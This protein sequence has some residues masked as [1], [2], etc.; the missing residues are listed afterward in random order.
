[1]TACRVTRNYDL[2][3]IYAQLLECL[4]DYPAVYLEAVAEWNRER[5]L[6]RKPIIHGED[7]HVL[8]LHLVGPLPCIVLV[9][10]AAHTH[11]S[12]AMEMKYDLLDSVLEVLLCCRLVYDLLFVWS[13]AAEEAAGIALL[14]LGID[15]HLLG[16]EGQLPGTE[17][18]YL[19]TV[20]FMMTPLIQEVVNILSLDSLSNNWHDIVF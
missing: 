6:R 15:G 17:N 12:T 4:S 8:I 20:P 10:E 2:F 9:L 18:A 19:N 5:V 16:S 13:R 7:H 1:M 11:K 14:S 3:W